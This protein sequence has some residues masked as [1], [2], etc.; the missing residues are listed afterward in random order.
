[1]SQ[2]VSQIFKCKLTYLSHS[3]Y[4]HS[5]AENERG[6]EVLTHIFLSKVNEVLEVNVIPVCFNIVVDEEVQLVF[7][8]VFKHK[9]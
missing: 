5:A 6:R 9:G 4:I 3:K 7:D 1:M 8:P 2:R